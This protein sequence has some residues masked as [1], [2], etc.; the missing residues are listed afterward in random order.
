MI[1]Y[2]QTQ[3]ILAQTTENNKAISKYLRLKLPQLVHVRF[4][5]I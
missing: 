3:M 2:I 1:I 4:V 5:K